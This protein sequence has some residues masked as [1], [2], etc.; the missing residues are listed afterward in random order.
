MT[1]ISLLKDK[2]ILL[3]VTGSIA[4][5]K[6]VDL[7]SKLTQAGA[8]VDVILTKAAQK[9]VTPL[10]FQ[11]VTG[12]KAYVDL[13]NE[14]AHVLH[15]G[16][17]ETADLFVVAPCTADTMAKLAHGRAD[18]L[19]TIT[20]LAARC[21]M[22]LAPAMDGGMWDHP[23]TQA[24]LETLQQRGVMFAG[25]AEGRMAS[26]LKGKGRLVE[27]I[28]LVGHIRLAFAKQQPLAGRH[29]VVTAGGTQEAI[30]PVRFIS[31]HSSG[32]Q[33]I[34]IAQA[35]LDAGACVTLITG[36]TAAA[37]P[38]PV[39]AERINITSTL[40]L[41]QATLAACKTAD[42]L[43]MAAAVA[44]YRTANPAEQK[45]KRAQMSD[46][47]VQLVENPDITVSV[48]EQKQALGKPNIT[49]G[50]AAESQNLLENAQ[51]KLAKKSLDLIVGNDISAKDA[52][53]FVDTNRVILID[54]DGKIERLPL[55]SKVA[56]A[57]AVI[58]WVIEASV[59]Q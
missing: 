3:G 37:R 9:F 35:A 15:I 56:V 52:G 24:N 8:K 40:D 49:I 21:P 44:D 29:V 47:S 51:R 26:G 18:N 50:F 54:K 55:Q 42:V 58:D 48:A 6:I 25:P 28:D 46:L 5:Y 1:Q 13:W 14:D 38:T 41:Q 36:P 11:S 45:I 30:D 43:V 31:N 27:P 32:K 33:G 7:A 23:A 20:A 59:T 19:L 4:C 2:H 53:F 34:A 17:G 16:L 10:A 22:L 57:E 39:G 12:R